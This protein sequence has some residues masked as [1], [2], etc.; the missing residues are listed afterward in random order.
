MAKIN[1]V[2]GEVTIT[3]KQRQALVAD[4]LKH[5]ERVNLTRVTYPPKGA[6][7]SLE[8]IK[9]LGFTDA[10]K[11]FVVDDD[12]VLGFRGG[13]RRNKNRGK[14]RGGGSGG[15]QGG[16]NRGGGGGGRT[17]ADPEAIADRVEHHLKDIPLA[18]MDDV[19]L[20]LG[21]QN[22]E[23]LERTKAEHFDRAIAA[24]VR[25]HHLMFCVEVSP[26][27]LKAIAEHN[28]DYTDYVSQANNRQ[29]AVGFLVHKRLKV[30]KVT[31][32]SN[33]A[34]VFGIPDLRSAYRLD[35]ED[36]VTGIK[37]SVVV[38]HLKSMRGGEAKTSP[39][40][41]QQAVELVKSLG[42]GL[43][44]P[45]PAFGNLM[46][47]PWFKDPQMG[48]NLTDHAL[49]RITLRLDKV[50]CVNGDL[51]LI[52]GDWNLKLDSAND[53]DPLYQAG[54][55]QA[56]KSDHTPT[57]ITGP[58]KLDAYVGNGSNDK[59]CGG[60]NGGDPHGLF[61][62]DPSANPEVDVTK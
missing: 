29:Q 57:Q 3:E 7:L 45:L 25:R 55:L 32:Y 51:I 8:G 11:I 22:F 47:F 61:S 41:R 26:D 6:K 14:Q 30:L 48:R 39:V 53:L 33:V 18:G 44:I 35:L 38:V 43:A 58:S 49:C 19:N 60:G 23:N 20:E 52:A 36:T 21:E 2:T 40:R 27:G 31:E 50:T 17:L 37:F 28:P 56:Y 24:I 16:G 59:S 12:E 1:K 10:H 54:W 62:D 9:A 42:K 15:S 5:T 34:N 46:V 13:K 4:A